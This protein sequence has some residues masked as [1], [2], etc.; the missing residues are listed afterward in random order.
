MHYNSNHILLQQAVLKIKACSG[1][2]E[3]C[4]K[5]Y[6]CAITS[7]LDH[8]IFHEEKKTKTFS[9]KT[10]IYLKKEIHNYLIIEIVVCVEFYS[11]TVV[12]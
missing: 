3:L 10:E 1:D 2:K 8:Y 9:F 11:S 4:R 5:E 6:D 12:S 7:F